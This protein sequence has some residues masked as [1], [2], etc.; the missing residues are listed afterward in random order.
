MV[1]TNE[2]IEALLCSTNNQLN[3]IKNQ[4]F[5]IIQSSSINYSYNVEIKNFTENLRSV[6]DYTAVAI[7]KKYGNGLRDKI[8]FP[9]ADKTLIETDFEKIFFKNYDRN[10]ETINIY[11]IVKNCQHFCNQ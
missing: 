8:Y 4:Y 11:S 10:N 5:E 1:S 9:Y 7:H 2:E 6:L 3:N